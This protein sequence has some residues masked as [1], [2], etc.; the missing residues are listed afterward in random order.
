MRFL[1]VKIMV[2]Q[3]VFGEFVMKREIITRIPYPSYQDE[4]E[5][6]LSLQKGFADILGKDLSKIKVELL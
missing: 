3:R 2:G 6:K 5:L 4:N 1:K